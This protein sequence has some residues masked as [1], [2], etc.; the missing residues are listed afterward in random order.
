MARLTTE[1]RAAVKRER[2]PVPFSRLMHAL[3]PGTYGREE[4]A[5]VSQTLIRL[6]RAGKAV[7]VDGSPKLWA[8]S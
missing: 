4:A 6:H 3:A 8:P 1:A 2:A 5:R 7:R